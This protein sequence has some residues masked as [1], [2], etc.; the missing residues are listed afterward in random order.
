MK[1]YFKERL[2]N[3]ICIIAQKHYSKTKKH[4]YSM[5]LYKYLAL[6]EYEL[7]KKYGE[8]PLGLTY[9]ALERGP[10]PLE[11]YNNITELKSDLY[12]IIPEDGNKYKITSTGKPDYDYF[13][14]IEKQEIDRLIDIYANRFVT[15]SVMSEASHQE[16]KAWKKTWKDKPNSIIDDA[17]EFNNIY[18]KSADKLSQAEEHFLINKIF[19]E[20]SEIPAL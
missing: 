1:P 17:L 18:S 8:M 7:L 6:F 4:I 13:S 2:E 19:Q 20:A 9:K 11:I 3:I 16:I 14:E 5:Y 12:K 10:V 15:A